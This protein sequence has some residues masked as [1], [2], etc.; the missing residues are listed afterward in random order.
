MARYGMVI[1]ETK[2]VGC[3]ACR[4]ACQNVNG[5]LAHEAYNHLEEREYGSFPNY[6]REFLPVQCQHCDNPPCVKVCPTGASVKRADGI[7]L[8]DINECIGCKYC[9]VA[10]PYNVR[11]IKKRGYVEKCRF[12]IEFLPQGI[13]PA[14][15][16]TCMAGVR[17]F[18]DLDDPQSEVYKLIVKR[19]LKQFKADQNTKPRIY[20]FKG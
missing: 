7:V 17:T 16:T 14:C 1:D 19:K 5:L 12:C 10:C 2:C 6:S 8:V 20:Y 9:I 15:L 4:V 18:G 13:K 3:H 11:I